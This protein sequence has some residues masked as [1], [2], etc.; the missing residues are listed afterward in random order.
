MAVVVLSPTRLPELTVPE[1][2]VAIHPSS[3]EFEC[4]DHRSH[5][6]YRDKDV[7]PVDAH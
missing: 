1:G 2:L 7:V 4:I 3:E 6:F 5:M